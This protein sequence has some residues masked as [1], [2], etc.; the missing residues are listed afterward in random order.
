M[1]K[2]KERFESI[3]EQQRQQGNKLRGV[4]Y[5]KLTEIYTERELSAECDDEM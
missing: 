1:W 5:A 2:A 3:E 4:Y